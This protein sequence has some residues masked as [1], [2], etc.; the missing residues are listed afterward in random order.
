M[1]LLLKKLRPVEGHSYIFSIL[2]Y[3]DP[4]MLSWM[5]RKDAEFATEQEPLCSTYPSLLS[6]DAMGSLCRRALSP[7]HGH[8]KRQKLLFKKRKVDIQTDLA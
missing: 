4:H 2:T 7:D 5:G 1:N 3:L 6:V 8:G